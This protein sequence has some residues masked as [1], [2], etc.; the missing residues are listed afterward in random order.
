M[1]DPVDP[2]PTPEYPNPT[3]VAVDIAALPELPDREISEFDSTVRIGEN[4]PLVLTPRVPIHSL[5]EL[6]P[7]RLVRQL[8]S[9]GMGL[10]FEV[11]DIAT[12]QPF[13]LKILRPS[14]AMEPEAKLRFFRE[15]RA[16]AAIGHQR[17]VPIIRVGEDRGI[18][19][20]AMPLLQGETLEARL[21]RAPDLTVDEIVRVG[22]EIAEGLGAA[23]KQG[24][25]HRDIKPANV[26]LEEPF[27]SVRLLD[28]GLAREID[29]DTTLTNTGMIMGTPA[30]MAPEQAR[31]EELDF[32]S[33]LFSL[34]CILYQ[35]ATGE[36]P[37]AG[38]SPLV[39]LAQLE[40]YN[41]PRV[42]AKNCSI[43]TQLSNLIME[44]LSKQAQNRPASAA[45]V[46]ERL[47]R[48]PLHEPAPSPPPIDDWSE[49]A[50]ATLSRDDQW[51]VEEGSRWPIF[52]LIAV[53]VGACVLYF[54]MR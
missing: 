32:R 20:I 42:S 19:F 10:V 34:G 17:I 44:L 45:D 15:A 50:P 4:H 46:I 37:F 21:Q 27:G 36:R 51:Q 39:I 33:D 26:W 23:H 25:I 48:I 29:H 9:G 22:I 3:L 7:Y 35:M 5:Q 28:L 47:R 41:P 52:L 53:S 18:P 14:L 2:F 24:L 13:A 12:G 43:P 54:V 8:G 40:S 6:G 38:Q 49:N 1:I 30:Y 31:G 16:M 11:V